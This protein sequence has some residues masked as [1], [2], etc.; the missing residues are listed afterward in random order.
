MALFRKYYPVVR[1]D[2]DAEQVLAQHQDT[3]TA[4]E[5]IGRL[6]LAIEE[7]KWLLVAGHGIRTELGREAEADPNFRKNGKRRDGYRPVEYPV[8]EALCQ[9]VDWQ[10]DKLFIGCYG[11][12]GRCV[13]ERNAVNIEVIKETETQIVLNVKHSLDPEVFDYPLTLNLSLKGSERVTGVTQGDTNLEVTQRGGEA[14]V[15]VI[16]NGGPVMVTLN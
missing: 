4:D 13:R 3:S 7:N 5:L 8:M 15:N 2:D 6:N 11:D 16:P 10:R 9:A 14:I 12:V 1:G